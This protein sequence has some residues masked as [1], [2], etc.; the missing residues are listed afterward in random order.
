[1]AFRNP[2]MSVIYHKCSVHETKHSNVDH[3][4]ENYCSQDTNML[5]K[6]EILT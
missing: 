3:F 1:M 5:F 2:Q 6:Q 4:Y